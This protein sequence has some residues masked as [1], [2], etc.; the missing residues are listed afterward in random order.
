M[1]QQARTHQP[2]DV[3]LLTGLIAFHRDQ[4]QLDKAT[5]YA[6]ELVKLRPGDPTAKQ[7]IAHFAPSYFVS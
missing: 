6:R 3:N 2:N 5:A 7:W 1:L 4:G